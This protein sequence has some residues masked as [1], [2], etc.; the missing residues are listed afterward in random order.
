MTIF[1]MTSPYDRYALFLPDKVH[2]FWHFFLHPLSCRY[3]CGWQT[4]LPSHWNILNK[5]HAV[6][7]SYFLP[8]SKR[9]WQVLQIT[10]LPEPYQKLFFHQK[11]VICPCQ[12]FSGCRKVLPFPED[13][14]PNRYRMGTCDPDMG[15]SCKFPKILLLLR[16]V[17]TLFWYRPSPH[18]ACHPLWIVPDPYHNFPVRQNIPRGIPPDTPQNISVPDGWH[19]PH[20]VSRCQISVLS[21]RKAHFEIL[22][23]RLQSISCHRPD[24]DTVHLFPVLYPKPEQ[25]EPSDCRHFHNAPVKCQLPLHSPPLPSHVT[26]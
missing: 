12:N 1:R 10:L 17:H 5:S 8:R 21:Y 15:N 24:P 7:R 26:P 25:P 11:A 9:N 13:I 6:L 3:P 4:A 23:I 18:R 22:K 20:R 19:P 16:S 2:I 14:H